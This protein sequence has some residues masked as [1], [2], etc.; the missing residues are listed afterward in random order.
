MSF[1]DVKNR[2]LFCSHKKKLLC[3]RR[4]ST[5][6]PLHCLPGREE[7]KSVN[8][9]DNFLLISRFKNICLKE[10]SERFLSYL[11]FQPIFPK[12]V[13]LELAFDVLLR[14]ET[15]AK[16][17]PKILSYKTNSSGPLSLILR[18]LK[19]KPRRS[20]L[21]N[22]LLLHRVCAYFYAFCSIALWRESSRVM[23]HQF[24]SRSG[25]FTY[26]AKHSAL[27][28]WCSSV[29]S[30]RDNTSRLCCGESSSNPRRTQMHY[31]LILYSDRDFLQR[32][33]TTTTAFRKMGA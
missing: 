20:L 13:R 15:H 28:N 6:W 23:K 11:F 2:R 18:V 17:S 32:T 10:R 1:L 29:R 16:K 27:I 19:V 12:R 9:W 26:D 7:R 21:R 31:A 4:I 3:G 22:S 24:C 14:K 5:F 25:T 8:Q 33:K 30:R